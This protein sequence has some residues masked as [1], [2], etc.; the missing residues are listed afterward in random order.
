MTFNKERDKLT[1]KMP[2]LST[3]VLLRDARAGDVPQVARLANALSA[4]M[5]ETKV[6]TESAL[7]E[8]LFGED[9][10]VALQCVVAEAEQLVGMVL[11]YPGYDTASSSNGMH[12]A[13]IYVSEGARGQGIGTRLIGVVAEACMGMG[14]SWCSLTVLDQNP[15]AQKFYD[16]LGFVTQP[17]AFQAIGLRGMQKMLRTNRN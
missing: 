9:R 7:Y 12:I 5:G 15:A 2:A 1:P 3:H 10:Q 17:V 14:G 6:I 16:A 13:D 8:A 4:A 11:F